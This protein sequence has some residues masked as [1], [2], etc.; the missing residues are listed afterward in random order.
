MCNKLLSLKCPFSRFNLTFQTLLVLTPFDTIHALV[1]AKYLPSRVKITIHLHPALI[2]III[3]HGTLITPSPPCLYKDSK[4][5]IHLCFT[6][7]FKS[8]I[9]I[10][11]MC[12]TLR[13]VT[14]H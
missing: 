12:T 7:R 2:A 8:K 14:N 1:M 4:G 9:Q 13:I 10:V 3:L 5:Q 6:C 11:S